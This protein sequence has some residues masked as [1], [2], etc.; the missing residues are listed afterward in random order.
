MIYNA[1]RPTVIIDGLNLFIRHYIANPSTSRNGESTGGIV[2]FLHGVAFLC[3][4]FNP[5]QV[6]IIW[7]AGGSKRKRDK[8]KGYKSGRRP[9]KLNRYYESDIPNTVQ[10]RSRQVETIIKILDN[11]PVLQIYTEDCEADDVIGYICKYQLREKRKVIVSSDKDYYQLLDKKTIIYSPTWKKFVSFKQV[12][13]KFKIS[14]ENFC[15]A[16]S[17][18]G[19]T[20]DCIDGVKGAGFKT[21]AKRFPTLGQKETVTID[22]IIK[23]SNDKILQGTK[24]KL[25]RSIVDEEKIIRRNWSLIRLDT[26]NLSHS[27]I[28]KIKY[29]FDTFSQY[30]NK[31]EAIKIIR[32]EGIDNL[33]IDR[34]FIS[35]KSLAKRR[36]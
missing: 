21:L 3:E 28:E 31:M 12:S 14:S 7:E 22:D 2:G 20:S 1:N 13:E 5:G 17:I 36:R 18:C 29:S 26:N 11:T 34:V 4:K 16:K 10:N 33:N 6:V 8:F 35:M 24:I 25:Y 27:I 15:L 23:E 19:D 32:K 9:Q 30:D